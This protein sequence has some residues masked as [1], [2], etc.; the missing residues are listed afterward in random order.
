MSKKKTDIQVT[1]LNP[2]QLPEENILEIWANKG[3]KCKYVRFHQPCPKSEDKEPVNEFR[4]TGKNID[5][6]DTMTLKGR[7]V[8][9][10]PLDSKYCVEFISYT[11]YGLIWKSDR[12]FNI[13]PLANVNYVRA[14]V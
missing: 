4:L 12:E 3:I 11:P 1:P 14:I 7:T 13:T 2:N 10:R 9:I 6:Q 8:V 5:G